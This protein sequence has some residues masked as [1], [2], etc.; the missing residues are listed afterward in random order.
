MDI[1]MVEMLKLHKS[2]SKQVV[3]IKLL[4]FFFKVSLKTKNWLRGWEFNLEI[5]N[6]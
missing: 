3:K 5:E 4:S 2:V 6:S 1:L